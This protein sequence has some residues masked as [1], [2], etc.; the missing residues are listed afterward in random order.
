MAKRILI[1]DSGCEWGGGTN[2][3][4]LLLRHSRPDW[5]WQACFYHDYQQQ[6]QQVSTHL[7]ALGVMFFTIPAPRISFGFK[8]LRE[9]RLASRTWCEWHGKWLA[10]GRVLAEQ[11]RLHQP[12][13]LYANNHPDANVPV[14]LAAQATQVP[15]VQH[16]RKISPISARVAALVNAHAAAVIC[17]S[18]D[19]YTHVVNAGITPTRC[20][21]IPNGIDV[22]QVL[23]DSTPIRQRYGWNEHHFVVGCVGSL[24]PLKHVEHALEAFAH[25]YQPHWR[26]LIVGDGPLRASLQT[27]AQQLGITTQVVF[28]GFHREV[29]AFIQACD[30]IVSCSEGEGLPRVLLE[31]MLCRKAIVASRV[32]G[33]REVINEAQVGRLYP[34]GEISTLVECLQQIDQDVPLRHALGTAAHARVVKHYGLQAY[35]DGV[36]TC[37]ESVCGLC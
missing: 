13:V 9:L 7:R 18:H 2:S 12:A 24:L 30:C 36:F 32:S 3:L 5:T 28:A 16:V 21:V 25:A 37:L 1:I 20:C 29:L 14:Y 10:A 34:F 31:A 26:L 11:V 27:L 33:S 15:V 22:A 23:P 4:L 6:G 17:V 35:V 8:L 19:V